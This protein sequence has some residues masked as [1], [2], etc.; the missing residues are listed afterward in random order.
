M[1]PC[2]P[3]APISEARDAY[4]ILANSITGSGQLHMKAGYWSAKTFSNIL[5]RDKE[6][7]FDSNFIHEETNP[8]PSPYPMSRTQTRSYNSFV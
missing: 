1:R 8:K 2:M 3:R 7:E 6:K 5:H 4:H